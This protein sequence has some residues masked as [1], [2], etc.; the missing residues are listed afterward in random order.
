MPTGRGGSGDATRRLE[1]G[2][3]A[4]AAGIHLHAVVA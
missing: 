4:V 2:E 1:A 3:Q